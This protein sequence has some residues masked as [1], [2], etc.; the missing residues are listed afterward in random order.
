MRYTRECMKQA[1]RIFIPD[2]ENRGIKL[3]DPELLNMAAVEAFLDS[4]N[5]SDGD[6]RFASAVIRDAIQTIREQG[7][8]NFGTLTWR[9][10]VR[11]RRNH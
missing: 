2:I 4:E 1:I 10:P 6:K 5:R 8:L 11:F 3:P 7:S 9:V